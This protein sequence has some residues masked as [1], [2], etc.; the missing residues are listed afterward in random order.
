MSMLDKLILEQNADGLEEVVIGLVGA[1]GSNLAVFQNILKTELE[2]TFDFDVFIIKVS[3]DILL[4]HPNVKNVS[5]FD[6]TTKYNRIDSLMNVGNKLRELHDIDYIALEVAAKIR[7]LRKS[8]NG[9]KKTN[10]I[11]YKLIKT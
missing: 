6:L 9:T 4:N 2:D 11:Y 8:Y 5:E 1:I 3:E 10:C 7:D